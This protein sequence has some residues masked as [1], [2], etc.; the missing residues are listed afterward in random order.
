MRKYALYKVVH[1]LIFLNGNIIHDY[2]R[3]GKRTVN[4]T[5][6]K[7]FPIQLRIF[8]F[9]SSNSSISIIYM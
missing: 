7:F 5:K 3:S 6:K 1:N 4:F 9:T 8:C 2:S